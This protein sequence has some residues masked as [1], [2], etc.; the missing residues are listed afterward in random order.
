MSEP[1]SLRELQEE[2]THEWAT[3]SFASGDQIFKA[4]A[5]ALSPHI[6]REERQSAYIK[7]LE[8]VVEA[9]RKAVVHPFTV[10][11]QFAIEDAISRLEADK[12][13]NNG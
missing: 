12:G 4:P 2:W 11:K 9:A 3:R 7:Q 6:N 10:A 13:E 1:K 5:D 8:A